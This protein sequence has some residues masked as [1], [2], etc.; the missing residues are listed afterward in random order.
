[1]D[2]THG[3]LVAEV[4]GVVGEYSNTERLRR[5][6]CF[7]TKYPEW[8]WGL[9]ERLQGDIDAAE[10]TA[11]DGYKGVHNSWSEFARA[12]YSDLALDVPEP[13][14]KHIDWQALGAELALRGRYFCLKVNGNRHIFEHNYF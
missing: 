14:R 11:E 6:H 2:M 9:L 3:F 10:A 4:G 8:G 13:L 1:M 12:L 5:A 7:V